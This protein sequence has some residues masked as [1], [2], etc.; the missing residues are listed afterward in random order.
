MKIF[1]LFLLSLLIPVASPGQ[2]KV[3]GPVREMPME[4]QLKLDK[5]AIIKIPSGPSFYIAPI[6]QSPNKFSIL[7]SDADNRTVADS[8]SLDQIQIFEAVMIEAEKF[9]KTNEAV[10]TVAA[11][12]ITRFVDKKEPSFIVDVEKT[13]IQS[14][15]YITL[16]CLNGH[17]TMDAGA[18]KRDGKEHQTLFSDILSRIQAQKFA[19]HPRQ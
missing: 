10:G 3:K 17:L 2:Q 4:E 15:F 13:G 14:R 6:E 19:S 1:G 8:F 11:P 12:Q 7:L 9:A 18:I 16:N 5:K